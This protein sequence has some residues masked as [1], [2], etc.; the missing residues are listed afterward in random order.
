MRVIRIILIVLTALLISS[1]VL[2]TVLNQVV[3]QSDK[4]STLLD[5]AQI[6]ELIKPQIRSEVVGNVS[7]D[8]QYATMF[9]SQ[10]D[11]VLQPALIKTMFQPVA[12]G[13]VSWLREPV[14]VEPKLSIDLSPLRTSLSQQPAGLPESKLSDYQFFVKRTVPDSIEINPQSGSTNILSGINSL[15][16]VVIKLPQMQL[17]LLVIIAIASILTILASVLAKR[18]LF[19]AMGFAC[20]GAALVLTLATLLS[21]SIMHTLSHPDN[22][23]V[24][25]IKLAL[26]TTA[27]YGTYIVWLAVAGAILCSIGTGFWWLRRRKQKQKGER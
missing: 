24:I 11:A 17:M 12:A 19:A 18:S 20:L 6:Y 7:L 4:V 10:L 23:W 5:S 3:Q 16:T 22:A 26:A 27:E 25:S 13:L 14:E 2:L 9:N 15:K 1:F 21:P 8:S